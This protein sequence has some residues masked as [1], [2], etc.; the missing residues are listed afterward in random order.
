MAHCQAALTIVVASG[1]TIAAEFIAA[2]EKARL[3]STSPRWLG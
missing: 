2:I 3:T 1:T